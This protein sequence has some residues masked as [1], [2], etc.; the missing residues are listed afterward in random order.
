MLLNSLIKKIIKKL[1]LEEGLVQE[2]EKL[3]RE[4]IKAKSLDLELL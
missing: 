2:E 3:L 1:E 4:D